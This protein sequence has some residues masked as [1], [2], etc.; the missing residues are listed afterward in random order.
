MMKRCIKL[1]DVRVSLFHTQNIRDQ[2]GRPGEISPKK[3]HLMCLRCRDSGPT[4][5]CKNPA[6]SLFPSA[7][8][9][10]SFLSPQIKTTSSTILGFLVII[11]QPAPIKTNKSHPHPPNKKQNKKQPI[12]TNLPPTASCYKLWNNFLFWETLNLQHEDT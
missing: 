10:L 12:S 11:A 1:S 3:C 8:F 6:L 7:S 5:R 9:L 2:I 4:L